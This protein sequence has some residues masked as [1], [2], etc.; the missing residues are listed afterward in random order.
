MQAQPYLT[1][2]KEMLSEDSANTPHSPSKSNTP[3]TLRRKRVVV[4]G[5]STVHANKQN[6]KEKNCEIVASS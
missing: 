6:K 2:L 1:H 4:L 3:T 5:A